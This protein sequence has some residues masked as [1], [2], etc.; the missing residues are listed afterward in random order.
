MCTLAI[1]VKQLINKIGLCLARESNVVSDH[2]IPSLLFQGDYLC[3]AV[4]LCLLNIIMVSVVRAI[5]RT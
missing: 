2:C 1:I 4:K 3:S 5:F